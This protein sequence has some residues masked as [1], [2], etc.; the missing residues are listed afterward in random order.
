MPRRPTPDSPPRSREAVVFVHGIWFGGVFLWPLRR[1]MARRGYRC[2]Q[3]YYYPVFNDYR[4]VS[5]QLKVFLQEI[6]ADTVHFV[7]HSLGGLLLLNYLNI[8]QEPRLGRSVFLGVPAR[9]SY[10][11]R[12]LARFRWGRRLLGHAADYGLLAGAPPWPQAAELGVIAGTVPLGIGRV[13]PGLPSPKDGTVS[14]AETR[15][16]NAREQL[17]LPVSHTSM[18]YTPAVFARCGDFLLYGRFKL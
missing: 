1:A 6:D 8:Y 13:F 2:R 7:C 5:K 14:V 4:R 10:A 15:I 18:L 12:A 9:G 17:C 3:F 16:D 11:A